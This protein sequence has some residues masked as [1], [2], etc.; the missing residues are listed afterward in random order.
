MYSARDYNYGFING[1]GSESYLSISDKEYFKNKYEW[2]KYR[3]TIEK[4]VR[5]LNNVHI[6]CNE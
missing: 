5:I 1:V 4:G 2:L 6:L 3:E